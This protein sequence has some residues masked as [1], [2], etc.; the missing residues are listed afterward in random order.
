MSNKIPPLGKVSK[1]G[2]IKEERLSSRIARGLSDGDISEKEVAKILNDHNVT[3]HQLSA[4][5]A[6]RLSAAGAELGAVGRVSQ[7]QKKKLLEELTEVDQRLMNLG[8]I[9]EGARQS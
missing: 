7:A 8:S 5:F 4:L 2:K 3:M 9:T 6:E 1:T